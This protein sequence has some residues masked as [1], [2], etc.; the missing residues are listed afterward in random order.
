MSVNTELSLTT[1]D[2]DKAFTEVSFLLDMFIETIVTFVGKS[3]PALAVAAG[4]RMAANMPVHL[5][6][7]SPEEALQEVVRVL[8]IQQMSIDGQ[9]EGGKAVI[10]I[11]ECPIGSVCR[12]RKMELDGQACQMFHYYLAGVMA[13]LTGRPTRPTT[14][15]AGN[16]CRFSLAF[17]GARP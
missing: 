11:D 7:N 4:R 16:S 17:A 15:A 8:R 13:E 9:F 2:Y 14:L 5:L 10:S 1:E 6:G 12:N 3:T